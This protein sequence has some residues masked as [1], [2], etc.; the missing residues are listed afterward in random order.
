MTLPQ[1][2]VQFDPDVEHLEWRGADLQLDALAGAARVSRMALPRTTVRE[3]FQIGH[4]VLLVR[5]DDLEGLMQV[6]PGEISE[7]FRDQR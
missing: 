5:N 6:V 4:I 3:Q 1:L 7:V 2:A